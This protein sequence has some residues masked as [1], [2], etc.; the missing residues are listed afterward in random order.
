[1]EQVRRPLSGPVRL[2]TSSCATYVLPGRKTRWGFTAKKGIPLH[3]KTTSVLTLAAI[4][5]CSFVISPASTSA[6][7]RDR[8]LWLRLNEQ[9]GAA[10]A[11]DSSGNAHRGLIGSHVTMNGRFADWDR[12]PPSEE[13]SY[14]PRHLITVPDAADDSLDPGTG[15]FSI[16]LRFRTSAS[17]GNVVQKGQATTP[18]GQVKLQIPKGRLSCMFKTAAGR[19]T[20]NSGTKRLDDGAWHV[21][22]CDRTP[23]SVT[24]FVDGVRTGRSNHTTGRLNNAMPWSLGGK[25]NCN[26]SPVSCDYFP[27]DIDYLVLTKG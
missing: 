3:L 20:A 25:S 23:T 12:H 11:R 7:T 10:A 15:N 24:M 16:T 2:R 14:G 26:G 5:F 9:A 8:V 4:G 27:G 21:V 19:A 22:R 17:F 1:M 6:A 18:G 13:R